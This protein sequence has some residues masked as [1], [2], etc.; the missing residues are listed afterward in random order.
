MALEILSQTFFGIT[1]QNILISLGI[2]VGAYIIGKIVYYLFKTVG[3][4]LTA[5]TK[6][7]L[8]D[9]LIDIIEEPIVAII[10]LVG[11]FIAFTFLGIQDKGINGLFNSVFKIAVIIV[12]AWTAFR[13]INALSDKI[14]IPLSKKTKASFD[15]HLVPLISKGAKA[16]VAVIAVIMI[17]DSIGFDVTALIAGL[18]IGGLAIAFAAQETI[19]NLFGGISLMLDKSIKIG[20]KIR[21]DSGEVGVVNEIGLRS[22]RIRT[23]SN[24]VIIVPNSKMANSKIINYAQPNNYGRGQ[25]KFGVT[26]GTEPAK[27]QKIVLD[28]L[29]NN[30]KVSKKEDRKP[31][32]EFL[33]MGDFSLNFTAKFWC[34][35]YTNVWSA[36][37]ELTTAIYNGLNKNKI[38]IPFPTQTVYLQK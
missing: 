28:I 32:V 10:V 13:F 3:R 9:V 19:S 37:R 8:D 7:D 25:I 33:S 24:E 18:G 14:L 31:V 34:D 17:M 4:K 26:Y 21:I 36:E 27:V 6:T 2:A 29:K 23:F 11:V 5:K 1:L 22:T 30:L 35:D 20:D 16:I 15:D 12:L 38:G